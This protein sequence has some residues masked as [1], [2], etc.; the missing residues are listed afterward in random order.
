MASNSVSCGGAS[1]RFP[2]QIQV[3]CFL[4]VRRGSDAPLGARVEDAGAAGPS[5]CLVPTVGP[6]AGTPEPGLIGN[7]GTAPSFTSVD[8]NQD[9]LLQT[10]CPMC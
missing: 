10:I 8:L 5:R 7:T 2:T 6:L 9:D 3:F 1:Y 4:A